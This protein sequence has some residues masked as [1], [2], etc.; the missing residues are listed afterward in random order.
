MTEA[1]LKCLFDDQFA[2][3]LDIVESAKG[4]TPADS[5]NRFDHPADAADVESPD[6]APDIF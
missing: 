1:L 6:V 5:G 3:T 4:G 2:E